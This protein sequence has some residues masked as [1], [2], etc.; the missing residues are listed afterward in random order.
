MPGNR[1]LIWS[2]GLVS[3]MLLFIGGQH[4]PLAYLLLGGLMPLPVLLVGRRLGTWPACLLALAAAIL[5][6]SRNPG[7]ETVTEHLG[8]GEM[9]LIGLCLGALQNRGWPAPRAILVTVT[10]LVL[11]MLAFFL[12]Q[13]LY[14]G[15]SPV[16]QWTQKTQEILAVLDKVMEGTGV[17]SQGLQ[18]L[19]A[20][21]EEI[22]SRLAQILP[23][24]VVIN[25]ALVAWVNTVLGRRL[26]QWFDW[27]DAE[28]PLFL[29]FNPE[30][31]IFLVL[32]AG[33]LL[34]A[35]VSA[36]RLISLNLLFLL[37]FLYFC[38]G[39]AVMAALFHRLQIPWFLRLVG[40]LI[41]FMN[42]IFIVIMILGLMDLWLDFRRLHR[43]QDA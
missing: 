30:W 3:L 12:G 6:V 37:G 4:H 20:S 15:V 19:G 38:Q 40:Y 22:R 32:G 39:M 29:W 31:L 24:M 14:L 11:G 23:S 5:V 41:L 33:F 34:L 2:L 43:P 8:L 36:I 10:V 13:A 7:L 28:P 18:T 9:L 26:S 17:G 35:P 21:A 25:T 1:L 16:A 27:V 42:P